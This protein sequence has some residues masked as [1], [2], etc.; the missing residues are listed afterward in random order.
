[1]MRM[2]IIIAALC[3]LV[4]CSAAT[5]FD[6]YRF[7]DS[8]DSGLVKTP[9]K[10]P[11][12]GSQDAGAHEPDAS[13]HEPDAALQASLEG[14]WHVERVAE[15]FKCGFMLTQTP[16]YIDTWTIL[17]DSVLSIEAESNWPVTTYKGDSEG[18]GFWV[19]GSESGYQSRYELLWDGADSF[20]GIEISDYVVMGLPCHVERVVKGVKNAVDSGL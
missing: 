14:V 3:S 2:S 5:D 10:R 13:E 16:R 12:S 9:S 7:D 15:P 20:E 4:A 1:M 19:E 11:D 6:S 18:L 17:D 8:G